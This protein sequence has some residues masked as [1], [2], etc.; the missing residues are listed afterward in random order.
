MLTFWRLVIAPTQHTHSVHMAC[1]QLGVLSLCHSKGE[2]STHVH[3]P[4]MDAWHADKGLQNVWGLV[5]SLKLAHKIY[6]DQDKLSF[7]LCRLCRLV[8]QCHSPCT[9]Y[10]FQAR[11]IFACT[12]FI[13][14]E[15]T[16]Y[17]RGWCF[18]VWWEIG[19]VIASGITMSQAMA[20]LLYGGTVLYMHCSLLC[21]CPMHI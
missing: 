20:G 4:C 18:F 17:K 2:G 9:L 15:Y 5:K 12:Q 14:A 10:I 7:P 3:K 8:G 1:L 11:R 16:H 21:R 13:L 6:G 19:S